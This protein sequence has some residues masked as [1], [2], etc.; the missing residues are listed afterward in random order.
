MYF[1]SSL[2]KKLSSI[3]KIDKT[4]HRNIHFLIQTFELFKLT[5]WS[6]SSIFSKNK[7]TISMPSLHLLS[8]SLYPS[9]SIWPTKP[10][11]KN[12]LLLSTPIPLWL[13]SRKKSLPLTRPKVYL[14]STYISSPKM[15]LEWEISLSLWS[16]SNHMAPLWNLSNRSY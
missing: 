14:P 13:I 12:W 7:S 10:I 15:N 4:L 5:K 6:P 11:K 16:Y 2:K 1:R 9:K 8:S 3:K